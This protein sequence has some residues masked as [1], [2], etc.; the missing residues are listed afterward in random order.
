[1][2]IAEMKES[3]A[4]KALME[5]VQEKAM[6]WVNTL[7]SSR[8]SNEMYRAQGALNFYDYLADLPDEMIGEEIQKIE[9]QTEKQAEKKEDGLSARQQADSGVG[10]SDKSQTP[11]AE[12]TGE[13]EQKAESW[14]KAY[15]DTKAYATRLSQENA[16]LKKTLE[17]HKAG[18]A[19]A[20]DGSEA[21]K[22]VE[23][24]KSS[25]DRVKEKNY[26]E[27]PE[28]KDLI[29]PILRQNSEL[30]QKVSKIESERA[31]DSESKKRTAAQEHFE[32]RVKPDVVKVH[33]DFEDVIFQIVDGK[34]QGLNKEYFEWAAK[35]RPSLRTAALDSSD[36]QD[37]IFAVT[38]FKKFK[39]S[40]EAKEIKENEEK[41]KKGKL[42]NAMSLRGGN[43]SIPAPK[44][45][46]SDDDV[47][48]DDWIKKRNKEK[49]GG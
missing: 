9:E 45:K 31:E 16:E 37:I 6:E 43:A 40:D 44:D 17:E 41:T 12:K 34:R 23:A 21:K 28:F 11:P 47:P 24:A 22:A 2:M 33:P 25:L 42:I 14:Q 30:E 49:Y 19:S 27:Y 20:E 13:T 1:M 35:Q 15:N 4:F 46:V 18:K 32:I 36:P 48:T 29:E 38:E 26:E 7:K 39:G 3:P 10:L 8:D 5:R